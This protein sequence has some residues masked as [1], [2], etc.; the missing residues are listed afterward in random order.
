MDKQAVLSKYHYEPS[1][2][3]FQR[4]GTK[5]DRGIIKTAKGYVRVFVGGKYLMAHHLVWLLHTG[6]LPTK[7]IDH[8]N[9][10]RADNRF[11][12]LREVSSLENSQNQRCAHKT[13]STGLLGAS[14]VRNQN[15]ARPRWRAQIR[16]NGV[17]THLGMF[18]SAE[19]AHKAYLAA[20][21]THHPGCTI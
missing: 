15:L 14:P 12:N 21:R 8:I 2:G 1:T 10:A 3:K 13:S 20:K 11:G 9:G 19:D 17:T 16:I 4:R 5:P 7:Q 6:A 18:S